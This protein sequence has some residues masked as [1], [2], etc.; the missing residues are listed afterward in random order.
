MG[1]FSI[2]ATLR[3]LRTMFKRS[4]KLCRRAT[5]DIYTNMISSAGNTRSSTAKKADKKMLFN[6]ATFIIK[7]KAVNDNQKSI[8]TYLDP[9]T[10]VF[11]SFNFWGKLQCIGI[12]T[13]FCNYG[14]YL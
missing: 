6:N 8:T 7:P 11:P 9:T 3:D 14:Y 13:I 4:V 10:A 12:Y 1:I 2:V 5:S